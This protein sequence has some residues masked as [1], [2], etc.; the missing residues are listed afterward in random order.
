MTQTK[1]RP[2]RINILNKELW[3]KE[4]KLAKR[5]KKIM[6]WFIVY[7]IVTC[8][9]FAWCLTM[10]H[11]PPKYMGVVNCGLYFSLAFG[12]LL[13]LCKY[14]WHCEK[15]YNYKFGKRK[16]INGKYEYYKY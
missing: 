6:R 2:V 11:N 5:W 9:Y 8:I 13:C 15:A 12:G 1:T 7:I 3:E 16:L 4:I 14:K 10:W